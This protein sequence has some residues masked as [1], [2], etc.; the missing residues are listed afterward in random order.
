[1]EEPMPQTMKLARHMVNELE[2]LNAVSFGNESWAIIC[3][4]LARMDTRWHEAWDK[5]AA[6]TSKELLL[7]KARNKELEEAL[8]PFTDLWWE[9]EY[10]QP[11]PNVR[12][13]VSRQAI[14][15]AKAKLNKS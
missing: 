11:T 13:F 5:D 8:S 14:E 2:R 10:T 4:W 12:C 9:E 6:Q 1:M 7:L 15:N 3:K